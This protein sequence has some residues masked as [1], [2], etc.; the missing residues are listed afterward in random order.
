MSD[1]QHVSAARALRRL[2]PGEGPLRNWVDG[3]WSDRHGEELESIDP[4]TGRPLLTV[5]VADEGEV[6]RAAASASAAS[7][8]W[9][10]GDG[11]DRGRIL[12]AVADAIRSRGADLGLADTLDVGRPIRDTRTRDVER[13]ARLFEFWAGV[14]DRIRGANIPVQ[15]GFA[16]VTQYEPYGVV[17]AIAPW[18]Y[19]LTNAATK[20]APALAT[21]N[22][23]VLKPAEES[24]VSALLLASV[25]S[26]AGLPSGLL[27]VVN[28]P[29]ETTGDHVV[30]HEG[31]EKIAFTGSTTVGRAIA[32]AAGALLK[33]VSL[34]LGGKS[35]TMVFADA[36]IPRAASAVALSGFNNQ[37]QTC[38][39]GTRVYV[40]GPVLDEFL[41]A[42]RAQVARLRVG[43][44]LDPETH[45]G[46]LVSA[47]QHA[48][49]Q[50]YLALGDRQ[51]A[52]RV[53]LAPIRAH[54]DTGYFVAPTVF[55]HLDPG[56][57]IDREEIFGP[58][59]SLHAFDDEEEALT[60]ANDT[61]YGL[62]ASVWTQ[63]LPRAHRL[64]RDLRAGLVWVNA[65]H[66]LH[67]GSPYGGYK[68]SGVGLEMGLEAIPQLM[69][70][71]SVWTATEPWASP[72]GPPE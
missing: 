62:S 39:A 38:T 70:V 12:R 10:R 57:R 72:W 8:A 66:A 29:G 52:Q 43:D 55:V 2:F 18:N 3:G 44:P 63:S 37:G 22:G 14:T 47:A 58:V 35:P 23:V 4:T 15:P 25:A 17:G 31:I 9:W 45:V 54:P 61:A 24:P 71:K 5:T 56:N 51:S 67:P 50:D 19:P 68:Q 27:N 26:D 20:V 60:A 64:S 11:Q 36:D 7:R 13:A 46:P 34:E 6:D 69:K 49:V 42:L 65:V 33:S 30:R 16:N 41:D 28:G 32:S 1:T 21:G 40:E 59:V 48:R 53:E